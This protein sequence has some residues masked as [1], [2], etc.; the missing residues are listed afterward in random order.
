MDRS[1]E[2]SVSAVLLLCFVRS[3]RDGRSLVTAHFPYYL[4]KIFLK[5]K[6]MSVMLRKTKGC[7]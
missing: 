1:S 3:V 7:L 5:S 4:L 2:L 6:L